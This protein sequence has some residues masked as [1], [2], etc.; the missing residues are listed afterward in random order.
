VKP[1]Y[2]IHIGPLKTASTY[3]QQCLTEA[4]LPLQG[5]GV[6]YP[7][8]LLDKDANFMHFPVH[9][10][11][12]RN[13]GETLRPIF[14]KLNASGHDTIVLSSEHLSLLRPDLLKFLRELTSADEVRVVY[15]CRRWSDRLSSIWNQ[16]LFMGGTQSLPE[17]YL[18][19][20]AGVAPNYYPPRLK[21]VGPASDLDYSITWR[22]LESI[23]G[24]EN[25]QIFPYS[26]IM[27]RDGDLF[28]HFCRDILGL[29]HVP[30]TS[31]TGTRRWASMSTEDQ[32]IL[33]VLNQL[34]VDVYGKETDEVRARFNVRRQH[35]DNNVQFSAA[36]NNMS[37]YAD[38]VVGGDVVFERRMKRAGYMQPGYLLQDSVRE[39]IR[40]IFSD[41]TA[42]MPTP[43]PIEVPA[44]ETPPSKRALRG[45]T[46]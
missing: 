11:L 39:D 37:Q 18:A 14:D 6:C 20:L 13:K 1:R 7:E 15:T 33:R 25:L 26:D 44:Q 2:I 29:E 21:E 22:S 12:V 17:F 19:M 38:R 31:V 36:Y 40:G 9:L 4:R 45:T 41:I 5:Q 35:Y 10:A 42:G 3:L 34:Y 46:V 23:F 8:E 24:R 16:T 43:Q 27:D 32:E 30:Q 28:H